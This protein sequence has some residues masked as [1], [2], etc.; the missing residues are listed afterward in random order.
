MDFINGSFAMAT[1]SKDK[2]LTYKIPKRHKRISP[3]Y[4]K[5]SASTTRMQSPKQ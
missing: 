1:T 5:N 2:K 4:L 3:K